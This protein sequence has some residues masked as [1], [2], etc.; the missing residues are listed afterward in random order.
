M[1]AM[2]EDRL[3]RVCA[4]SGRESEAASLE[5]AVAAGRISPTLAVDEI[6]HWRL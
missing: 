2:L 6:A 1:W 3:H 5:A 4:R